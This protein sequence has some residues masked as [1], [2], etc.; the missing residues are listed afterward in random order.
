MAGILR[1]LIYFWSMIASIQD[2][3]SGDLE[4][5]NQIM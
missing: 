5:G 4:Y 2:F 1:D 3:P